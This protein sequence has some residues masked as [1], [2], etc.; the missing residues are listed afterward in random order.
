MKIVKLA[1]Q[2]ITR[3]CAC[4]KCWYECSVYLWFHVFTFST[5]GHLFIHAEM[6]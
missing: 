5:I 3:Q 6:L 1:L 4:S 2:A